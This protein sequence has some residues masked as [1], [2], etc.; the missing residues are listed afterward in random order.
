MGSDD[1]VRSAIDSILPVLE[2]LE[3]RYA[4][5]GGAAVVLR[6]YNRTTEDLGLVVLKADLMLPKLVDS[7]V[8]HGFKFRVQDPISFAYRTR[9]I[10]I[11]TDAG[12]HIDMS[13]GL[14]PFEE[15]LVD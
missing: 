3:L 10:L 4:I 15:Q 11:E 14:I 12:T 1:S 9:M 6:G 8:A 5:I 2:E 7:L 13:L